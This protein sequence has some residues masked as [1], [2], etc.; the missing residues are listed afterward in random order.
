MCRTVR[1]LR[2]SVAPMDDDPR[3]LLAM[4]ET[5]GDLGATLVLARSGEEA[6]KHVLDWISR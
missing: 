2:R 4:R 3:N 6:L 5:L 1:G